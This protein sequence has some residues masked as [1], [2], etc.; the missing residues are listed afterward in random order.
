MYG[1]RVPRSLSLKVNRTKLIQQHIT[2]GFKTSKIIDVCKDDSSPIIESTTS[3]VKEVVIANDVLAV[4][5]STGIA[6][7]YNIMTGKYTCEINPSNYNTVHTLVYNHINNTLII[8]YAAFPA[9]LQCKVV[10][11]LELTKGKIV[12]YPKAHKFES[13]I[14]S[15]PAFFEFCETNE[16]IGSANLNDKMYTFWNMRNYQAVFEVHDNYQEIRVSDGLVAM[17][18]QPENN[19]IPL[20][21]YD[22]E[23]GTKLV[24]SSIEILPDREMQF[25][26]LLVSKLMIKQEGCCLRIYDLLKGTKQI[27][28]NSKNFHPSAFVFYDHSPALDGKMYRNESSKKFFTVS[29]DIVQFWE[30]DQMALTRIHTIHIPGMNNPDLLSHSTISNIVCFYTRN[31]LQKKEVCAKSEEDEGNTDLI[32]QEHDSSYFPLSEQ[33][34]IISVDALSSNYV[35]SNSCNSIDHDGT[36]TNMNRSTRVQN[37]KKRKLHKNCS[38]VG[39]GAL[40]FYGLNDGCF[41]S[42]ISEGVIG[43]SVEVIATNN[44]LSIIAIGTK[45]GTVRIIRNN[46]KYDEY[47]LKK[48]TNE[49]VF[50]NLVPVKKIRRK[51]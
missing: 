9:H 33:G 49:R 41:L 17:F 27:V 39:F 37:K 42:Q 50:D 48:S 22:I 12:S 15:H 44:T 21:L 11:C 3:K 16:R 8:A 23:D 28:F 38:E 43:D 45:Y 36:N 6:K 24:Q 32:F 30:L 29:I 40:M 19:I 46:P 7:I 18:K 10:D 34:E 14:L 20:A 25:L 13:V 47:E 35:T 1:N 2:S 51:E 5:L 4:L 31:L 26:E